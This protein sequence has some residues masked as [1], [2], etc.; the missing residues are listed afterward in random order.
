MKLF[1]KCLVHVYMSKTTNDRHFVWRGTPDRHILVP[2][3]QSETR[4]AQKG[5]KSNYLQNAEYM[6]LC[7]KQP[8]T[9][10]LCGTPDR[11]ILVPHPQSKTRVAQK[12]TKRN[13]L[14]NA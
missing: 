12:G 3:P 4:V 2:H 10:I 9:D 1:A 14:Q 6:F 8:I 13:F 7:Q 5:T 11:H